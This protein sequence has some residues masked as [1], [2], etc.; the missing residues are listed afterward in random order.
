MSKADERR[1]K[2]CGLRKHLSAFQPG[3]WD[4]K[5]G[6]SKTPARDRWC[7]ECQEREVLIPT[8]QINLSKMAAKNKYLEQTYNISLK[9]YEKMYMEQAGL[10][11]IC[12]KPTTIEKPFLFVDHDHD[13]GKV[14]GLLCHKCNAG[15]GLFEDNVNSLNFA[16]Q[17]L[18]NNSSGQND[19]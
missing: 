3:V 5:E 16:I 2:C 9:Q 11:A 15:I 19:I 1:C 14:R 10:C 18:R 13:T 12:R 8:E 7:I 17:Y 4:A 6:S